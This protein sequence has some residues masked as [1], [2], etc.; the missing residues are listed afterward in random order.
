MTACDLGFE[1][2]KNITRV[3]WL[4]DFEAVA[5]AINESDALITAPLAPG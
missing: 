5:T 3:A 4:L 1:T 2:M